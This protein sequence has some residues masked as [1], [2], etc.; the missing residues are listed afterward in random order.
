MKFDSEIVSDETW[1]ITAC[2]NQAWD[3]HIDSQKIK[4]G[5]KLR[6]IVPI[7]ILLKDCKINK[8]Q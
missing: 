3:V 2:D 5:F 8:K 1:V 6:R 4:N 7:H